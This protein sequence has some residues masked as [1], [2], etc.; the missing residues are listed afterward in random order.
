MKLSPYKKLPFL[1]VAALAATSLVWVMRDSGQTQNPVSTSPAGTPSEVSKVHAHA[2]GE[3][4]GVCEHPTTK[5]IREGFAT[6][7][8]DSFASHFDGILD[9]AWWSGIKVQNAGVL[10]RE[11]LI[12]KSGERVEVKL[13]AKSPFEGEILTRATRRDGTQVFG[14]KL[15][16]NGFLLHYL[17]FADGTISGTVY[18]PQHPVSYRFAGNQQEFSLTRIAVT[19]D[20]CANWSPED[21]AVGQ[22]IPRQGGPPNQE[23]RATPVPALVSSS[24]APNVVYLDFDGELVTGTRW[25][26]SNGGEDIDATD[27]GF[28]DSQIQTIWEI[29][30]EDFR[31]FNVNVTTDRAIFDATAVG[32]RMMVIFTQVDTAAPGAGGVAY[33]R[34]FHDGS[35]DPCWVFN[36]G[37]N[38]AALAASHEVGHTLNLRHDGR[39]SPSEE[40]YLG[41]TTWG[42]IMGAPYNSNVSQWSKGEYTSANNQE[43]DIAIMASY[44]S[45]VID[46]AGNDVYSA[47]P[48][49]SDENGQ[50]TATGIISNSADVDVYSFSASSGTVVFSVKPSGPTATH[51]LN[52]KA[53]LLDESG[54]LIR[55]I[56]PSDSLSA[57]LSEGL[58]G[59]KFFLSVSAGAEGTWA[60]G[61][62]GEYGS[63]GAYE[64]TASIPLP[65]PGDTDGDG[66]TDDEELVLGT[67]PYDADTDGDGITDRLEIYPFSIETQALGFTS[68]RTNAASKGGILATIESREK[69][70]RIKRGLLFSPHPDES[71]PNNYDPA[72]VLGQ[73]L[74]IGGH[75]TS[76]DGLF[77]WVT[78]T[79][80]LA[81]PE[82]GSA[83]FGQLTPGSNVIQNVV[84]VASLVLGRPLIGSGIRAGTTITSINTATRAVT[85]SQAVQTSFESIVGQ[86]A[87]TNSGAGYTTPP[88]I[89]FDPAGATATANIANGRITSIVVTNGGSYTTPPTIAITGGNGGGASASAVLTEVGNGRVDSISITNAGTG[90]TSIPTVV[91]AGGGAPPETVATAVASINA[92][93]GKVTGIAVVKPGSGYSS[94]PTITLVG[95]GATVPATATANLF[96]S[97][98]RLYSPATATTYSNWASLLPGNRSNVPE[99]IFLNSGADFSWG[100]AQTTSEYGYLL[101]RPATNPLKA[102]TDG[103]GIS[104]REELTVHGTNPTIADTDADGLSDFQEVYIHLTNPFLA[105]TDGDGLTDGQEVN[106]VNGFTSNPLLT[107]TDGDLFSDF[108]EVNATSP[109]NPKDP[110]SRPAGG[111]PIVSSDLHTSPVV[112]GTAQ[113]ISIDA[114]WAPFGNR[115]DTD[116]TSEDGSVAIRD[117]NGA[118]I[119]VDNKGKASVLPNSSLGKTLYV[120]NSECVVWANRYDATYDVRGST[121]SV[122]I[123]RRDAQGNVVSSAPVTIAGTLLETCSI[124]PSTYGFTLVACAT[125]FTNPVAESRQRFQSGSNNNGPTYAIQNVDIWDARDMTAYRLTYDGQLQVLNSN[126]Q[127]VPRNIGNVSGIQLVGSGTDG[128][129]LITMTTALDFFDDLLDADPGFFKSQVAGFWVTWLTGVEQISALPLVPTVDPVSNAVYVSNDRLIVETTELDSGGFATGNFKIQDIRQR[130]NGVV[131]LLNAYSLPATTRTLPVSVL[132]RPGLPPYLYVI[133]QDGLSLS[134]YRVDGALVPLGST[135]SLPT[136]ISTGTSFVRNPRD[137]SLLM[138]ASD[139]TQVL[140]MPSLR[141]VITNAIIGLGQA[142][143]LPSSSLGS[144]MFVSSTEAVAWMNAG[145][146]PDL[147]SGG[148]VPYA[149]ISHFAIG[150]NG[151]LSR[152]LLAPPIEGRF[153][154]TP[155][156]LSLDPTTEGWFITTF[157]KTAARTAYMRTFRLSKNTNADRD[158]DGLTDLDELAFGTDPDNPDSDGDGIS[159]GLE[160]YPFYRVQGSFTYE[161]ARLDAIRRGGW[162]AVPDTAAKQAALKLLIGVFDV[163]QKCWLGGGDIDGPNEA[164]GTREGK[165]RWMDQS[166]RFFDDNGNPVGTNMNF[167]TALW[168][169]SQPSNSSNADGLVVRGDYLWEMAQLS[170]TNSYILQIQ[171]TNPNKADTDGDG[172]SDGDEVAN[173]TDPTKSDPFAG[174][175]VITSGGGGLVSFSDVGVATTYEGLVFDPAQGHVF[176]QQIKVSKKGSFSTSLRGLSSSLSGSLK[177][178]FNALGYFI[179][180]APSGL[181]GVRSVEMQM[182]QTSPGHWKIIGR[183]ETSTGVALGLE[184]RPLLYGKGNLYPGQGTLTMAISNLN[185]A[186]SG[187]RGDGVVEGKVDKKGKLKLKLYLPDGG[188]SSFSGSILDGNM[189]P[190]YG[191]SNSAYQS[192]VIGAVDFAAVGAD[193]DYDG[194][195][196][197]YAANGPSG[198]QFPGGFNQS[199]VIYGSRYVAAPKGFLPITSIRS[200]NY[201]TLFNLNGGDFGGISK[202]A[203]WDVKNKINIPS[204]PVDQ[205]KVKFKSKTGLVTFSYTLTDAERSLNNAEAS[206]YAVVL[207]RSSKIQGYYTSGFSTGQLEVKPND[208]TV[209][210]LTLISPYRKSVAGAGL[211]YEVAVQ[212]AGAWEVVIPSG[213]DWVSAEITSGGV[214][215]STDGTVSVTQGSGPGVVQITVGVNNTYR[216]RETSVEIAGV[217]HKI[218]Q[219]YR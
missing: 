150:S 112:S 41:T 13:G 117:L 200:I 210:E 109:T 38:S 72:V 87:V 189:L 100:S 171:N 167:A 170:Q 132:T 14:V 181:N 107:D 97:S 213:V 142:R 1:L 48:L 205:G 11:A 18:K 141:N 90:Y 39:T 204:S 140:W 183:M 74:W 10:P 27:S 28:T 217:L 122:V 164:F 78:P 166:G 135:I 47:T 158:G 88:T 172:M 219:D 146:I 62:F 208:G 82:I 7:D 60:A 176:H 75:D 31:G 212:T 182:V 160:V 4:C 25:N 165:Y 57:N 6:Q 134:L 8:G 147:A 104:D 138:K 139:N 173:G 12:A 81:G 85:L 17:E 193:R 119:W 128:A 188:L 92:T 116:K 174:V 2:A 136:Q 71:L 73:R 5:A 190:I 101:E 152:T 184:L 162:I 66:L 9:S 156:S 125:R 30:S 201:N 105:D 91:I 203:T 218:S 68:A 55:E 103:D 143:S 89:T 191:I 19:D 79:G 179:G 194:F 56:N 108:E 178:S 95:G 137:G 186:V 154:A 110:T 51:N 44:I 161:Q 149:E 199:R 45:Y 26:V 59:G 113:N 29:V 70:Y 16:D 94:A 180:A 121:S 131:S 65:T 102:D 163:G 46:D 111:T 77:R 177:G 34:S 36:S 211:V 153:V 67:D 52:V 216:Q 3:S 43:D 209:P 49:I 197:F 155:T 54:G 69:L 86:I 207:Q 195:V 215:D 133:S 50:A 96:V 169:P 145:A 20:Y 127:F 76:V 58:S 32:R 53:R 148:V 126:S 202:V 185:A 120:S 64:I 37:A 124:S 206:G 114:T 198:T 83:C 144:P 123:H 159:D 98:G 130:A 175:P 129:M 99:G 168:A 40:Y 115:P 24:S 196:R 22:G 187:P 33:L 93:T 214:T 15:T 157:E 106:G 80:A 84:N 118:I 42:P 151:N 63:I 21:Q 61:G 192:C 35:D 23:T